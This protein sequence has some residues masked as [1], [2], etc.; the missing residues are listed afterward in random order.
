VLYAPQNRAAALTVA[1]S[2]PGAILEEQDDLGSRVRL[3][4]GTDYTGKVTKVQVGDAVPAALRSTG[5]VAGSTGSS[6]DDS[7]STPAD[8][9]GAASTTAST[10]STGTVPTLA[11]TDLS[12]VNAASAGCA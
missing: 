10:K 4:L 2:V 6:S 5:G 1:A 11:S 8:G 12:S 3:L 9:A 7:S